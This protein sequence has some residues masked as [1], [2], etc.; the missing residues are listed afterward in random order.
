MT[1]T[2]PNDTVCARCAA[3]FATMPGGGGHGCASYQGT[4]GRVYGTYG[5]VRYDME[6]LDLRPGVTIPSGNLC[7]G[8]LDVLVAMGD[9]TPDPLY[10][11]FDKV[12]DLLRSPEGLTA[13]DGQWEDISDATTP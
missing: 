11:P 13:L 7:D 5:S 12:K 3:R 1:T 8:C 9:L 6:A 2:N 4:D 10:D